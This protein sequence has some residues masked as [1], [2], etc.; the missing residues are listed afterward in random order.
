MTQITHNLMNIQERIVT[1]SA[2]YQRIPGSVRLLAV[3][4]R[5][6]AS[7]VYEACQAGQTEFGENYVSEG[8]RKQTEL[9]AL[10]RANS[11]ENKHLN[12]HFI[13]RI[14]SNKTREV[15]QNFSWVHSLDRLK[16]ARRL[17]AARGPGAPLNVLIQVNLSGDSTRPGV[18]PGE[19][20]EFVSRISGYERLAVRGLMAMAPDTRCFDTQSRAF[21]SVKRI[22]DDISQDHEGFD[23][24]SMGMSGDLEA[25]I[26]NGATWVRI[27][28]DVFGKRPSD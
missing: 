9:D 26:A 21:A 27:G 28:T 23:Q 14:Q 22:H 5:H 6:P 18:E 8:L 7:A 15:A 13:G 3:S 11:N 12:W 17:D 1:A 24:L 2:R 16:T 25:A 20:A 10:F 19:V 4:K